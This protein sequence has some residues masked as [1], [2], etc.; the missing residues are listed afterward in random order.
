MSFNRLKAFEEGK[1]RRVFQKENF[2]MMIFFDHHVPHHY[3]WEYFIFIESLKEVFFPKKRYFARR[4]YQYKLQRAIK[5]SGLVIAM[6]WW[7]AL[8][9]NERLNVPEYKIEKIHWFFPRAVRSNVTEMIVDVATKHDLRGKYLIY[10]SG[11]EMHNNFDRILK[12]I[13]KLKEKELII[14]LII[15]CEET[16]KDLDVRSRS[17]EYDIAD[18]I[19]FLWPVDPA[20]EA[21]YYGQSAGVIFS[22]IYESFP[23]HFSK[24]ISYWVPIFANDIP[25]N[26]EV[27]WSSI[28][29][30]D[31]LSI[32]N[33]TDT[34]AHALSFPK[35]PN[36]TQVKSNF[37]SQ[38]SALE[39]HRILDLKD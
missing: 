11:N 8:E 34:I 22:S 17:I 32:H 24:A 35:P 7:S 36:Y 33:I 21:S 38:K 37:S 15:L 9:L 6:D 16:N 29:Y 3:K 26:K 13:R 2:W 25:A 23:F 12:T 30:L 1:A 4:T 27:M 14:Y 20:V 28:S 5:H 19:I 10:D 31:P 39:L 18:Q